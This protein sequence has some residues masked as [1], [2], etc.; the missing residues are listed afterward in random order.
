M[1]VFYM[2]SSVLFISHGSHNC[3]GGEKTV[4]E[5]CKD[6]PAVLIWYLAF[7][8]INMLLGIPANLLVLWVIHKSS[9]DSSTSDVFILHLALLDVLF[10]LIPPLELANIIFFTSSSTQYILYFF[11]GI[12]DS[13]PLFLS[14]I[15]LDRYMAVVHPITFREL[16]DRWHRTVLALVVWLI[17]LVYAACKC[18]GNIVNFDKVFTAMILAAFAFMVFCNIAILLALRQSGP[19]RDEMHP[20]KK[21]AFKMVLIILAIIVFNYFPPVALFPFQQYFSQ[22]VFRCYI[23][24]IAF[25]L[26]DF[27]SSIQPMLYL[28]KE[29]PCSLSCSLSCCLS[30]E[31]QIP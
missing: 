15:C 2:N 3:T 23:H 14:C 5:Y 21:R 22:N 19:D 20:V 27:S 1:E 30:S 16:K 18:V 24:Y 12:K 4:Y 6:M 8:F 11:Y 28:S 29:K 26:M 13:S 25:G 10:C 7:Q 9:T 31:I 17:T